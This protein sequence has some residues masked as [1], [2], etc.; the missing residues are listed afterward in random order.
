MSEMTPNN[1][2]DDAFFAE[3]G[4][5]VNTSWGLEEQ[6]R[7]EQEQRLEQKREAEDRKKQA[8]RALAIEDKK[9]S[10]HEQV[11]RQRAHERKRARWMS[12]PGWV[13][14]MPHT[15]LSAPPTMG[16]KNK[17]KYALTGKV[18]LCEEEKTQRIADLKRLDLAMK[19]H[20]SIHRNFVSPQTVGVVTVVPLVEGVGATTLVDAMMCS[21][22]A[23]RGDLGAYAAV[24]FSDERSTFSKHFSSKTHSGITLKHTLGGLYEGKLNGLTVTETF[25]S[26]GKYRFALS[27]PS[28]GPRR[29]SIGAKDIALMYQFLQH[30]SGL[31]WFD[32]SAPTDMLNEKV[33]S[34]CAYFSD[35]TIF[36]LPLSSSA[37]DKLREALLSISQM[38]DD[39]DQEA[40]VKFLSSVIVVATGPTP[41]TRTPEGL[42]MMSKVVDVSID[43][44]GIDH[45]RGFVIPF[46]EAFSVAPV[47]WEK[48][49]F[50]ASHSVRSICGAVMDTMSGQH[51]SLN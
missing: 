51:T 1:G 4:T 42:S 27:N 17:A 36:V 21:F 50:A 14:S 39:E 30:S 46:D 33:M 8:S 16:R 23:S 43:G 12:M 37:P 11:E 26:I 18:E 9:I 41:K 28:V 15:P 47:Q 6:R 5:L 32:V 3:D 31:A 48:A 38:F 22:A 19:S 49:R 24:D 25:P 20:E 13:R 40:W 2:I 29:A 44:I 35:V 34:V 10:Y 45:E 7:Q